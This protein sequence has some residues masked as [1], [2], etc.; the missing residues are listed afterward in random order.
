MAEYFA[1]NGWN[2]ITIAFPFNLLEIDKINELAG[3]I[4]LNILIILEDSIDF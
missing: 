3:K 1:E 4:N 2:D